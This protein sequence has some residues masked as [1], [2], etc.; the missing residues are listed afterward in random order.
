ML[1]GAHI[2]HSC[3]GMHLQGQRS[4][5]E[6]EVELGVKPGILT[7]QIAWHRQRSGA[8]TG[9]ETLPQKQSRW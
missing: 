9:R 5:R 3:D 1:P 7:D 8:E 6:M 2:Q 4:F